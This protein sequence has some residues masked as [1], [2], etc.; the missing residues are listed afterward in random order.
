[1]QFEEIKR[2]LVDAAACA[3]ITEY[4]I[5]Y[6][7]T[8]DLSA[9]TLQD[10]IASFSSGEVCGVSFRCIVDGKQG[11]ASSQLLEE[12]ALWELVH[13]ARSNAACIDS[14]DVPYIFEGS[15]KYEAL[16]TAPPALL[17]AEQ[18][19]AAALLSM[20]CTYA[21]AKEVGDGTQCGALSS[22]K[23]TYL[24]NSKGLSLSSSV[25]MRGVYSSAV[26]RRG[27]DAAEAFDFCTDHSDKA[28]AE[29]AKRAATRATAKLG[30]G[31]LRSG[32]YG[33]LFD[34]RVFRDFLSAFSPIFSAKNARDGLSLLAGKEGE[35]IAAAHLTLIDDPMRE[36][37]PMQ[38]SFDG[39]GVA[40]ARR[41]VIDGGVL[42]TLLYDLTTARRAGKESTGNGRRGNYSSPVSISPYNLYFSPGE[43][44]REA[45]L[46]D[47]ADG[48][49]VTEAKGFHAGAD[50]VTGDFSIECAGFLVQG[51]KC[52]RPVKSFTVAGNF[53]EL[54]FA[55]ESLGNEV[56]W[57]IPSTTA[58]GSPDVLLRDVSVA[59]DTAEHT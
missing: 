22:V 45:L 16:D 25:G 36:G 52:S 19:R 24:Y 23:E 39:E 41:A 20:K 33:V 46:C 57:G 11:Y 6:Q 49:F 2:V 31:T 48:I 37:N 9:E 10:E 18:T 13:A 34:G 21:S 35:T 51:G 54:L 17:S 50:A 44:S 3:G 58:F 27:E 32:K 55:V 1:M 14:E 8:E 26:V 28:I 5:Y 7:N 56:Y 29:M 40:T 47:L 43:K 53:Y 38:A 12:D 42:T 4:E 30:G 15:P 59:G